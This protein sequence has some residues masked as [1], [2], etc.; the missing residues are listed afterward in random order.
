[1]FD[2]YNNDKVVGYPLVMLNVVVISTTQGEP[3]PPDIIVVV[4]WLFPVAI[5]VVVIKP[6]PLLETQLGNGLH[7]PLALHVTF[8][9][10]PILT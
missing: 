5:V 1:V 2:V 8:K 10:P 3:L 6:L 7:E 4:I 9:L